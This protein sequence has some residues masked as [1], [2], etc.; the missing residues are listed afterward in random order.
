MLTTG[1]FRQFLSNFD[2]YLRFAG[3]PFTNRSTVEWA[4]IIHFAELSENFAKQDFVL[5][6]SPIDGI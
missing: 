2:N 5:L 4:A 6:G 1:L 3:N